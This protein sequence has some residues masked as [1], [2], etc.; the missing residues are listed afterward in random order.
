MNALDCLGNVSLVP[1]FG[2]L[3]AESFDGYYEI[4]RVLRLTS[5]RPFI[6]S[7]SA[8]ISTHL[9]TDGQCNDRV[10]SNADKLS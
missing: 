4:D 1:Y 7:I 2:N 3:S 10:R 5:D 9:S 6:E 8:P